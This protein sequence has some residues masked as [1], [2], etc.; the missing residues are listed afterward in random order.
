ME[1]VSPV[2]TDSLVPDKP[3]LGGAVA[4]CPIVGVGASAGGLEA[5]QEFLGA[6]DPSAGLAYVLVQHL[7]PNHESM[8]PELLSRRTKLPVNAITDGMTVAPDTVYLLPPNRELR[9]ED[10][11]LRLREF[12]QPR[13]QRRPIDTFFASLA[14]DQTVNAACVVLSGT[15]AD[16]SEGLRMVKEAGGLTVAQSP[17]EAKY[18]GMPNSAVSTGLV[19]LILSADEMPRNLANYFSASRGALGLGDKIEETFLSRVSDAVRYRTGHDF[20]NYKPSTVQRRIARR[21]QVV[22][23]SD[24]SEYIKHLMTN[25]DE[26]HLLFRDLLINVTSFF[27]DPEAFQALRSK[28][29]PDILEGRGANETVRIWVPA[30]SSGEEA[31][32]IAILLAE[33]LDRVETPPSISIFATDIDQTMLSIGRDAIYPPSAVGDV[34]PELL[35][36]YFIGEEKGYRLTPR[37]RDMVRFSEHSVIKDPPF[38][39]LDLISCR[40]LLIYFEAE[41]QGR[42]IP[43]F[44]YALRKGGYLFLGPSENLAGHDELFRTVDGPWRLYRKGSMRSQPLSLPIDLRR[45]TPG[46]R[47]TATAARAM[48]Q[49]VDEELVR[50]RVVERYAPP[51][52]LIDRAGSVVYSSGRTGRYLEFSGGKPSMKLLD[53]AKDGL[54]SALRAVLGSDG[55]EARRLVK[56][57]V[58]LEVDG[59]VF[60]IDVSCEPIG[61]QMRLIVFQD[62][63][64][65]RVDQDGD[66]DVEITQFTDDMRIRELEDELSESRQ[67][68]RTTIEELETSNEELKSSNE[69][70]MSMNEELQSANEELSTINDEL[71]TKIDALAEANDDIR[72]LLEST[73]IATMFLD[74][75][76]RMRSFTPEA[77][78]VLRLSDADKGRVIGDI[79]TRLDD[80]ELGRAADEVLRT[81]E[82]FDATVEQDETGRVFLLRMIPYRTLDD[83][84]KGVVIVLTDVTDLTSAVSR[85]EDANQDAENRL[86]EIERIYAQTPVAMGLVDRDMTYL[87]LNRRLAEVYGQPPDAIVGRQVSDVVPHIAELI[88]PVIAQVFETGEG[89]HDVEIIGETAAR[90]GEPRVFMTDWHPY[91]RDGEVVAVGFVFED[92]TETRQRDEHLRQ[93]M[94]ELQHRVKNVLANVL[95]LTRQAQRSDKPPAVAL[96]RL[97][98]RIQSMAQTNN[99]LSAQDWR[100]VA[101]EELLRAELP[102]VYGEDVCTLKGPKIQVGSRAAVALSMAIHEMA[103]N[104][105]KYGSLSAKGG[106]VDVSWRLEDRGQGLTLLLDWEESGGPEVPPEATGK[107]FGSTLIRATIEQS[108]SGTVRRDFAEGGARY[109]IT[110]PFNAL[111]TVADEGEDRIAHSDPGGRGTGRS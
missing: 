33:M 69:E 71:K 35:D 73:R 15:G 2:H 30:C 77:A 81:L 28:V 111:E 91:T 62:T 27:R 85:L 75:N 44:H 107:G 1:D 19:D 84:I 106:R 26:G 36:R 14:T 53:L 34:P 105:A 103:T 76:L 79:R 57:D 21:M 42:V 41:L 80:I 45:R 23:L 83:E 54:R 98:D 18:D 110:V 37:I 59:Q 55:G 95:A 16:G 64:E 99:L 67:V 101:L 70:M 90:P 104:A 4:S 58:P 48:P 68:L 47:D 82:P 5:F 40:N 22:G 38:S 46:R 89:R 87:R 3:E 65:A 102:S 32:S 109:A 49:A 31:Y 96:E 43:V 12:V 60:M 108:L 56:R 72:N 29:L 61:R 6:A 25:G 92:I 39:R 50:R 97:S 66:E 86:E 78:R 51:F 8:L 63:S 9:I 17:S 100:F 94:Y 13:G 20:N 88:A 93:L 11:V 24:R 7:D 52:V 74:Q 10:G